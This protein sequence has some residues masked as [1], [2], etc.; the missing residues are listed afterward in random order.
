MV[1]HLITQPPTPAARTAMRSDPKRRIASARRRW[2]VGM[3]GGRDPAST[4]ERRPCK[5]CSAARTTCCSKRK[6]FAPRR[7]SGRKTDRPGGARRRPSAESHNHRARPTA[8]SENPK[9]PTATSRHTPIPG[10]A[11]HRGRFLRTRRTESSDSRLAAHSTADRSPTSA[12]PARATS[13]L[14]ANFRPRPHFHGRRRVRKKAARNTPRHTPS[15]SIKPTRP[16]PT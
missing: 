5:T 9:M 7:T 11:P 1:G 15:P 12:P 16:T 8:D 13:G 10:F 14:N 2:L 4:A 6:G 3:K